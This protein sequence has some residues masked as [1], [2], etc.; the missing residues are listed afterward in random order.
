MH[1]D[2]IIVSKLIKNFDVFKGLDFLE[3]VPA[4][5]HRNYVITKDNQ[6]ITFDYLIIDDFLSDLPLLKENKHII[7]NQ[8]FETSLEGVF[9]IGPINS[10]KLSI[11]EQVNII[12]DYLKNP[13]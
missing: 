1:T 6:K 7:T 12:I 13:F 10:S 3:I 2:I 8:Y 9:A 11:E 5:V 4:S